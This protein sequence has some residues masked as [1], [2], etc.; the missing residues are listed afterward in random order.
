MKEN[1]KLYTLSSSSNPYEIRY[2][3]ITKNSLKKRRGQHVQDKKGRSYKSNWVNKV[4]KSGHNIRIWLVEDNLTLEGAIKAERNFIKFCQRIGERLT[5]TAIGDNNKICTGCKWTE[6]R[7]KYMSKIFKGR[8]KTKEHCENIS[9]SK[10]GIIL[11]KEHKNKIGKGVRKAIEE[12]RIP[13]NHY[14]EMSKLGKK[15]RCRPVLQIANNKVIKEWESASEIGRVL[16]IS[17]K[18]IAELCLKN[19]RNPKESQKEYMSFFWKYK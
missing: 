10:K 9:K 6:E 1:Y 15:I 4:L 2:I 7:K 16:K 3:G 8:V 19:F 11:S 12:G 14:K 13:I 5:N 18:R 17:N